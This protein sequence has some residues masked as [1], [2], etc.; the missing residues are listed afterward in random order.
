MHTKQPEDRS[1][2]YS[3]TTALIIVRYAF[4]DFAGLPN[5]SWYSKPKKEKNTKLT[6]KCTKKVIECTK[7]PQKY[8]NLPFQGL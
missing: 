4:E 1:I 3:E 7:Y 6:T 2:N 5:F 8:H